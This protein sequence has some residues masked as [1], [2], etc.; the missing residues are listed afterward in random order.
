MTGI[1]LVK[2]YFPLAN[3]D[4]ADMI[5]WNF[6]AF[7]F[8]EEAHYRKQLRRYWWAV[9][10]KMSLCDTCDNLVSNR[11]LHCCDCREFWSKQ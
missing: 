3:D 5:L 9:N 11:T 2:Q 8:T 4:A 6:T 1:E 7:P 10:R